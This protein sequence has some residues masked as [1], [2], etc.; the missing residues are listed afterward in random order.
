VESLTHQSTDSLLKDAASRPL[1]GFYPALPGLGSLRPF[2]TLA[3]FRRLW[4]ALDELLR[5]L[6]QTID[7]IDEPTEASAIFPKEEA[8]WQT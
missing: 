6:Q 4:F 2:E 1:S 8:S 7:S 3:K 5:E